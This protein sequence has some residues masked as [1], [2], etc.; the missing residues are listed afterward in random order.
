MG[1]WVFNKFL[2]LSNKFFDLHVSN[3]LS[4]IDCALI[5]QRV[6][7][8]VDTTVRWNQALSPTPKIFS[9]RHRIGIAPKLLDKQELHSR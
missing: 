8:T 1:I 4:S 6:K 7:T 2:S 9:P 3:S 5:K